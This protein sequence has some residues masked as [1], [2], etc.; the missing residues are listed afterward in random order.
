MDLSS[1]ITHR[2]PLDEFA[3]AFELVASGNS[4]KVVL[5]PNAQ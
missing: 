3:A 4:G 1:I 5:F 2:L